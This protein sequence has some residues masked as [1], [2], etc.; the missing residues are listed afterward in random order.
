MRYNKRIL[1]ARKNK[2]LPI[3]FVR[4]DMTT[5]SGLTLID[6]CL[7]LYG[8]QHRLKKAMNGY[9]FKG[10]YS[11]GDILFVLLIM[12]LVGAERLKHLD[13]LRS[14]PLFCR[15]VRL[16]RI[17]HRTK[18]SSALKQFTSDSLKALIELNS[19]L[20][21]DKLQELGLME[22]TID[23]DGTVITSRGN[24]SWAF[25]GYNPIK[26]GAKS[27]FPLT[28]HVA[29]TGH[30]LSIMNRPGNVHDSNRA[31]TVIQTIHRQ[32]SG[33]SIGFRADSAFCVPDV[34][35]YLLAKHL[36]FAIKAPFWKIT[37]LKQA[38]Q[39]R[40]RWFRIDK[41]WSYFWI[42]DPI[43]SIDH[44]HYVLVLRKK[45]RC[46]EGPFQLDLF[47]PN[48]GVYQYS[49]VVTDSK[50]WDP[51]QLCLFVS[52]RSAQENSIGELKTSFAFDHIPTN[53]YQANSA[54]MQ[55]SQMAYN[56]SISM[57]HSMGLA[58]ENPSN[59]KST[60]QHKVMEWRTFR[61]L[62]LNRAGRIA[63]D[64]GKKAL[65][66]TKNAAT[67]GLY[68]KIAGSLDKIK[69]KKVA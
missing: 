33:F 35:N 62:I 5:Y 16:T 68:D 52:G 25:K 15:V 58:K 34:I 2:I 19:E 64:Q 32:L 50:D 65:E 23:L 11:I 63:W 22:I 53:T 6:H 9:G 4:Q 21:V 1:V 17:P 61:F 7:R 48:N 3:K 24:P 29:E 44:E 41:R 56:L 51:A 12:L 45:L 47:S 57:Q 40:K 37:A 43:D 67:K 20:V 28:A 59:P 49:A 26:K 13:Y 54:Y 55:M 18:L 38:V 46:P 60:R 30:F 66:M 10:D 8:I 42:K 31:L 39:Q 36:C 14:D 27:Y 69:F